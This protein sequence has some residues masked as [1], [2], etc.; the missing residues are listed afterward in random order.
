MA[1]KKQAEFI[2][3]MPYILD[4]LREHGGS[5]A[6]REVFETVAKLAKVSDEK[7]F[8]KMHSGTLRFPNQVAWAR[9]YLIW[10]GLLS[11]PKRGWWVL[12]TAGR[13]KHLSQEEA[14]EI[15]LKWVAIHAE[16]R[17]SKDKSVSE[18]QKSPEPSMKENNVLAAEAYKEE[19]LT[20]LQTITPRAFE[21]FCANL[22]SFLGLERVEVT[23]GT[24]DKGIDGEG[25]LPVGP[26]VTT[27]I[28]FQCKRYSGAVSPHEIRGFQGAIGARAEKGIFFTTGYFTDSARKAAR[29]NLSKP[30]ELIDGERL[31][32]LLEEHKFGL[33][34]E[35]TYSVDYEFLS[36]YEKDAKLNK[37]H[38]SDA[39]D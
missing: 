17:G 14:R 3:W 21:Q 15:F 30:I 19:I 24:G 25:Y 7:R 32:E 22:L 31:I 36:V 33:R 1:K 8:A 37:Q 28:A 29:D 11:A 2:Q 12:T 9:Q 18:D 35:T 5:A 39:S 6:P 38:N 26:L 20:Y 16:Q 27:K 10:E 4:S 23:G 34:E 13:E